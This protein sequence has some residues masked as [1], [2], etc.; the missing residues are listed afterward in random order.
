MVDLN[1]QLAPMVAA[2]AG[3]TGV[4]LL[5]DAPMALAVRIMLVRRAERS[6]DAQ[7]YIWEND[8]S[9]LLLLQAL[10]AAADRGVRVRLLLDDLGC[11]LG[12]ARLAA[13]NAHHYVDVRLFNPFRLR[14]PRWINFAFDFSRLNRRMHN[15]SLTIDACATVVGGRNIGDNYFVDGAPALAADLDVLAVGEIVGK[16]CTD[17]ERY[18]N[19]DAAEPVEIVITRPRAPR[20]DADSEPLRHGYRQKADSPEAAAMIDAVGNFVWAPVVMMSDDPDKVLGRGGAE[21]LVLPRLLEALAPEKRLLLVSAYFVPMETGIARLEALAAKGVV[22][23][24]LTNSFRSSDVALVHA[25]YAPVRA[26]LLRAGVVLWEMRGRTDGK[27]RL[28]LVPKRLRRGGDA[29]GTSFFR[30]SASGL[31]AKTFSADGAR[32]FVGSINFD[33]RSWRLNTEIG[34]LIDS[35]V[36]AGRLERQMIGELPAF[37]W[38]VG[39]QDGQLVWREGDAVLDTEPGTRLW[40][41]VVVWLLGKLPI[42]WML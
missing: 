24:V 13:L 26:R 17:F 37:A 42:A 8:A 4:Q 28:G 5:A 9:G 22:T 10:V 11:G 29:S 23:T 40:Q 38:G 35:E 12:D 7:F 27:A 36:L 41:R 19:A 34:F 6:I 15:K 25:G 2:N 32:L 30:K 31:H 21:E 33:P 20:A 3:L 18:W 39:L 16:V 1:E 14:W